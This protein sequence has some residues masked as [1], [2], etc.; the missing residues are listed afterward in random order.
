M[1]PA[2]TGAIPGAKRADQV[3]ENIDAADLPPLSDETLAAI[4]AIYNQQ[5]RP[6]VHQYW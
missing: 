4:D 2:V 1:F 6:S 3:E 5:V